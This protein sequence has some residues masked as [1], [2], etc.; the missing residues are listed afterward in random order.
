MAVNGLSGISGAR[1]WSEVRSKNRRGKLTVCVCV[2][3]LA[4]R[5]PQGQ[6]RVPSPSTIID[7]NIL[8]ATWLGDLL[9]ASISPEM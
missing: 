3:V 5:D 4:K 2:C 6:L 7:Y 8:V 1:S 9:P